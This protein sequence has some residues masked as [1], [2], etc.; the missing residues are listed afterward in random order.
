MRF[1]RNVAKAFSI[2]R[3]IVADVLAV[4]QNLAARRFEK[5][6]EHFYGSAFSGT[7]GAEASQDLPGAQREG[8][9][10]RG[11]KRGVPLGEVQRFEHRLPREV[12]SCGLRPE[13]FWRTR[14]DR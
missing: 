12:K 8:H 1:F 4:E 7:V 2:S 9:V 11:R 6:G 13:R 14:C 3:Q 10:L 5:A